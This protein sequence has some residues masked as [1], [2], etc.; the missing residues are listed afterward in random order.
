MTAEDKSSL[1]GIDVARAASLYSDAIDTRAAADRWL[2]AKAEAAKS[3]EAA[4]ADSKNLID[5]E[6]A[7]KASGYHTKVFRYMLAPPLSQDQFKL[8]CPAWSKSAEK[9]GKPL[10]QKS[11]PIV[12]ASLLERRDRS[13]TLWLDENREPSPEELNAL[14]LSAVALLALQAM[15]TAS[16]THASFQ[17]EQSVSDFLVSKGWTCVVP[18]EISSQGA[19][20]RLEFARKVKCA[21]E[22]EPQEVDIACG[23]SDKVLLAMECKVS[24]DQ[25]NSIKRINDVVKKAKAWKGHWGSF[26]KTAALL[27]GVFKVADVSRLSSEGV[28]VFWSHDLDKFAKW[29]EQNS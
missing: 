28:E 1:H 17:Q 12:A 2:Q 5:V 7:L 19:L 16:R 24:N 13:L 10:S 21:T 20:K 27:Q 11:A 26:V 23:L 9:S 14:R 4:L 22:T 15:G 8:H 29:L 3:V 18:G 25:T 6:S